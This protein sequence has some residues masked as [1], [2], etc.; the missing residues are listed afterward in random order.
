MNTPEFN[1]IDPHMRG[2]IGQTSIS[3]EHSICIETPAKT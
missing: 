2:E 1:S 3:G